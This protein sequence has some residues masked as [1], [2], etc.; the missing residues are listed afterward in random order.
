MSSLLLACVAVPRRAW[1]IAGSWTL[2]ERMS[3]NVTYQLSSECALWSFGII[4]KSLEEF[5]DK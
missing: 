1:Y 5:M 4:R 2:N 3:G